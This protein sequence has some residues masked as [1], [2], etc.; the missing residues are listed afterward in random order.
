MKLKLKSLWVAMLA[1]GMAACNSDDDQV[2]P[3]PVDP[4]PNTIELSK[5]GAYQSGIFAESAAEI[6]AYDAASKRLFVVNAQAGVLDVLD[7]SQPNQPVKIAEIQVHDIAE[8][9]EVNSVAVHNG[10]VA[11][12]I[13]AA[14]KTDPG[15]V[16]LYQ[17]KDLSKL[18]HV[19]VGA[20]PD[21]LTFSPDG[22]TLLVAN[23]GEPS[24]DYQVDPEGSIS[25]IQLSNLTAPVVRTADFK[26][27]NGQEAV[28]RAQGVRI[29]GPNATAAQDFEPEY[30]TVSQDGKTAWAA[31]QE[32][33]ALA[34]IDVVNAKVLAVYPLGFKDHGLDGNGMDVSDADG[35]DGTGSIKIQT[36]ANVRGLYMP[37]AIASFDVAGKTYIVTA[38]EGDARAWGED[39]PE[40]FNNDTS[41][42]FVEEWRVKHLVHADGFA[43]RLGDDL[44][45]HLS[46]LA[47]GAELN[48]DNFGYCG[49]TVGNAGDCRKDHLLGRLNITWTEGYQKNADGTPKL[50]ERGNLVYD[51]LY[52]FGARSVS[53]W[54]ENSAQNG[55][56][57]VWDSGD[58]FEQ[59]IA[60]HHP[61]IFNANHEE[62]GMDNRSDNKGPEP[63]GVTL[64]QIGSK[65]FA[66]IGLERAGGVM[67][68]DVST[69]SAPSFVQY[70]NS[71]EM[72]AS[73]EQIE[74]GQAG[75]LGPEG[76]VFIAAKDSPNGQPLL[77][78]GNEVSGSTAVYQLN[79]K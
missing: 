27:F 11:I 42:G 41:K 47:K 76:L 20:L 78:V 79:L 43:R 48:P 74:L 46:Q 61:E 22:Q 57:R 3:A 35:V 33:N 14:V 71:R 50:N 72:S 15:Y 63:E 53:I 10:I 9:A 52:S 39:T 44:P 2:S 58:D 56:E 8:G 19:Q 65:T 49:A 67:V 64:G 36:W 31:L 5:I 75:D 1:V 68:Y 62:A 7:L 21:M 17:A 13:Q 29:F 30:I 16:A 18:A 23:E 32:N 59:Y 40:Y 55:L 38:N 25:V 54:T 60:E 28:L 26:A 34:K 73:T 37:D 51:H 12:A 24:D 6:P 77:V 4:T 70:L 45:A 66:F 69:P